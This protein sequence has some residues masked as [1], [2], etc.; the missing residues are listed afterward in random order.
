[1][2]PPEAGPLE[3]LAQQWAAENAA[4]ALSDAFAARDAEKIEEALRRFP[5]E[6]PPASSRA[7]AEQL[8]RELR[9]PVS[10]PGEGLDT[11]RQL[12]VSKLWPRQTSQPS[13]LAMERPIKQELVDCPKNHG[14]CRV[15][16]GGDLGRSCDECGQPCRGTAFCC[17]RCHH[18]PP[19]DAERFCSYDLCGACAARLAEASRVARRQRPVAPAAGVVGAAA[20]AAALPSV[21]ASPPGAA[22]VQQFEAVAC[23]ET[24]LGRL[25]TALGS[26]GAIHARVEVGGVVLE[27]G[28]A[29]VPRRPPEVIATSPLP[30]TL[31]F[32][33]RAKRFSAASAEASAGGAQPP[34]PPEAAD[35]VGLGEWLEAL[36]PRCASR[37]ARLLP[38][39]QDEYCELGVLARDR[40]ATLAATLEGRVGPLQDDERLLLQHGVTLLRERG[41]AAEKARV[42]RERRLREAGAAARAAEQAAASNEDA[43]APLEGAPIGPWLRRLET[44]QGKQGLA[45][46]APILSD[47]FA[48]GDLRSIARAGGARVSDVLFTETDAAAH[49]RYTV[50]DAIA[51]EL[52]PLVH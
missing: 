28:D 6:G 43:S 17:P 8:L 23:C 22:A 9:G 27:A 5:E 19:C 31:K 33:R 49:E 29:V 25:L 7:A 30:V 36:D 46:F 50:A 32:R 15:L 48:P 12:P 39:L 1:M 2:P 42:A 18:E 26:D 38:A 3:R 10:G 16:P 4:R 37:L 34:A 47:K 21:P 20:V 14:L 13:G 11:R 51:R 24:D 45:R 52:V 40:P 35:A 41:V 44:A